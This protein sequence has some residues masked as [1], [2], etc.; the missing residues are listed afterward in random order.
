M[1]FVAMLEAPQTTTGRAGKE[2]RIDFRQKAGVSG[3][4][5]AATIKYI[6]RP[7]DLQNCS[8]YYTV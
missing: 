7:M 2:G 8:P 1:Y 6:L 3:V 5:V 4:M